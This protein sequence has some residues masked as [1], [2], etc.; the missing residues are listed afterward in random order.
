[1][2]AGRRKGGSLPGPQRSQ[3]THQPLMAS[4]PAIAV[5]A[6][7]LK[8]LLDGAASQ[9]DGINPRTNIL[10]ADQLKS[11]PESDGVSIFL[12]RLGF[13]TN[14]RHL[15]PRLAPD[16]TRFR[17]STPVDAHFLFTAWAKDPVSQLSL[18]GWVVRTLQDTPVLPP[19]FLNSFAGGRGEVF[20]ASEGVELVGEVLS[21]QDFFN[22]WEVAQSPHQPSV[23]YVARMILIDS[24]VALA[25]GGLVQT[26]AFDLA[27]IIRDDPHPAPAP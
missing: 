15:P 24:D 8:G 6:L 21:L 1:M 19:G 23:S 14:R 12:Y 18:L 4:F 20:A 11:V 13:N 26:R 22:I 25:D 9:A 17:A 2:T 16:G 5:V 10:R 27:T 7:A 3:P